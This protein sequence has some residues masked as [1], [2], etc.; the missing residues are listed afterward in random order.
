[1]KRRA[2]PGCGR[3]RGLVGD[4]VRVFP[5]RHAVATPVAA[6]RPARQ[7]LAGI[8]LSLA[9]MQQRP[10]GEAVAQ[11]LEQIARELPLVSPRAVVFHSAPSMS[12]IET[13]V[14]SPPMV[15]RTSPASSCSS[16]SCPS[17]SMACHCS[18]V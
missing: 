9:V 13:N 6:E 7:R 14:G 12:S 15:S 17:R 16:I 5:D 3:S 4:Q 2:S 11:P 1:M 8:A 18:S 10:G